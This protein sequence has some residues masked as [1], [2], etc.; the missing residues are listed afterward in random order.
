MISYN[1]IKLLRP[2][3]WVKNGFVFLPL[4]FD[5]R[6]MDVGYLIPAIVAFFAFSFAASG[7]Y[8]FNDIYD[9]EADRKHPKKRIRPIASGTISKQVAYSLMMACF[10]ASL[11]LLVIG[12]VIL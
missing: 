11:F 1:V 5:R 4:F 3:Q 6:M 8:C 9:V 2:H 10:V 7:I 12:G